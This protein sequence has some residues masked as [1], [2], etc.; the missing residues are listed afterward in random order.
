MTTRV[1]SR[2]PSTSPAR[3][4]LPA[5]GSWAP[6]AL[7]YLGYVSAFL[8]GFFLDAPALNIAGALGLMFVSVV[9]NH[10]A[11]FRPRRDAPTAAALVMLAAIVLCG[12]ANPGPQVFALVVKYALVFL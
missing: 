3:Q 12:V 1:E 8:V 4:G 9:G 7:G 2:A 5:A 11:P 6:I 10:R